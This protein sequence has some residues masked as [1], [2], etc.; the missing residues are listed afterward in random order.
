MKRRRIACT[1]NG[2]IYVGTVAADG[3][4]FVGQKDDVTSDCLKAVI[5]HVG[6]GQI[7]TVS[8]DGAPA[9]TIEV[10]RVRQDA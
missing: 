10:R 5:E 1:A 8:V 9:W 7:A 3:C 2:T 6:D 4:T